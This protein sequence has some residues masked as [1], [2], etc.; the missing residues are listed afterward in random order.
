MFP[1]GSFDHHSHA[2][3]TIW[4][5]PQEFA[6][7]MRQLHRATEEL[8][9]IV[10]SGDKTKIIASFEAIPEYMPRLP[11][12][13]PKAGRLNEIQIARCPACDLSDQL[14]TRE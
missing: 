5:K 8:T 11:R 4:D 14:L 12:D 1:L 3:P 13:V 2:L 6:Q 9:A 7:K 10:A